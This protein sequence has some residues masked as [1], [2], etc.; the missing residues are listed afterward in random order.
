MD[1]EGNARLNM[2][3]EEKEV[4]PK[5]TLDQDKIHDVQPTYVSSQE[6]AAVFGDTS[7]KKLKAAD[8]SSAEVN[9]IQDVLS[10]Q[11]KSYIEPF[12]QDVTTILDD[13]APNKRMK[14][15]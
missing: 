1:E 15:D 10:S 4:E 7:S 13:P 11:H 6:E 8:H 12:K 3:S 2:S 9:K 5:N 14:N